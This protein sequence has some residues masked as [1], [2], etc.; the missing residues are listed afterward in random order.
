M[1]ISYYFSLAAGLVLA[2]LSSPLFAK[3][4]SDWSTDHL[5]DAWAERALAHPEFDEGWCQPCHNDSDHRIGHCEVREFSYPRVRRPVAIDGG[6]NSGMTVMGW[7]RDYVRILYRVTTRARTE[8]RTRALAAEVQLAL[9]KGWLRPDGPSVTPEGESGMV[10]GKAWGA[11]ARE[12]AL[13]TDNGAPGV[14]AGHG[15]IAL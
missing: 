3:A 9:T 10:E 15:T 12:L 8:E 13:A 4:D 5:D 1:R 14:R 7:N 6:Q 11:R 2:A